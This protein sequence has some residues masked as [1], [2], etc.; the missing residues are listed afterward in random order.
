MQ[1]KRGLW[2]VGWVLW[3]TTAVP[4]VYLSYIESIG[5]DYQW[6]EEERAPKTLPPGFF[7][8]RAE[9]KPIDVPGIG[10]AYVPKYL[11]QEQTEEAISSL[12]KTTA[13]TQRQGNA[14]PPEDPRVTW[15]D[16]VYTCT[17]QWKAN[18]LKVV[19][20]STLALSF[21]FVLI[22]GGFRIILWV[23]AGFRNA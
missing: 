5:P 11:T 18:R 12:Q 3:T 6:R 13:A 10:T 1:W 16:R 15:D 4:I 2:R 7:L 22:Q 17:V 20:Y 14:A 19:L 9:E 23:I 8:E 21:G